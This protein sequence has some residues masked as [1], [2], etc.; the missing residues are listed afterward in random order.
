[1]VV[2]QKP[3]QHCKAIFF[4]LKNKQIKNFLKKIHGGQTHFVGVFSM[5]IPQHINDYMSCELPRLS[6][7]V[8]L[9]NRPVK[10]TPAM[11]YNAFDDTSHHF[12]SQTLLKAALSL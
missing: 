10:L 8:F 12:I 3:T 5:G 4:Q 7:A 9:S 1:M 6:A 11:S 2:Q